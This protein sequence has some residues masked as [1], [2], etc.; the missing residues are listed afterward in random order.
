[1]RSLLVGTTIDTDAADV[2][3]AGRVACQ[4]PGRAIEKATEMVTDQASLA[5][6]ADRGLAV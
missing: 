6:A 4:A 2:R 1:V 5:A 3:I